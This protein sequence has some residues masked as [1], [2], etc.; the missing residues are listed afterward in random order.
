MSNPQG[1]A[2]VNDFENPLKVDDKTVVKIGDFHVYTNGSGEL[3]VKPITNTGVSQAVRM[4]NRNGVLHIS[5][6]GFDYSPYGAC[7]GFL[8]KTK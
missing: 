5:A 1:S 2:A 4:A 8:V 3:F 6:N 7:P